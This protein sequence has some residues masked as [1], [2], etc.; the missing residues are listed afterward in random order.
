MSE[1]ETIKALRA[2]SVRA[3]SSNNSLYNWRTNKC[4]TQTDNA[5]IVTS[6]YRCDHKESREQSWNYNSN[7][8]FPAFCSLFSSNF[9]FTVHLILLFSAHWWLLMLTQC[10]SLKIVKLNTQMLLSG[11]FFVSAV[12]C[13]CSEHLSVKFDIRSFI[14]FYAII[15]MTMAKK[16]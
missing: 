5:S 12:S 16:N 8:H 13:I 9:F 7:E 4:G 11:L 10:N 6:L 3:F 15:S 14:F 1:R 2:P